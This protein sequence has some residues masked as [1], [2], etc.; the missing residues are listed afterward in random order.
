MQYP[1]ICLPCCAQPPSLDAVSYSKSAM[2]LNAAAAFVSKAHSR[3][4]GRNEEVV[5]VYC[6]VDNSDLMFQVL[7]ISSRLPHERAAAAGPAALF[8]EHLLALPPLHTALDACA[9][10]SPSD[11]T[12]IVKGGFVANGLSV[13]GRKISGFED[14]VGGSICTHSRKRNKCKDCG[15]GGICTHGRVRSRCKDCLVR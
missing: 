4:R 9:S 13:Q 6:T 3:V 7:Q 15:G 11:N 12:S 14:R 8:L 5:A 2:V 10:G 1:R